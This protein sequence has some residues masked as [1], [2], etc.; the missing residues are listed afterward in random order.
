M[1]RRG[2]TA[3][4]LSVPGHQSAHPCVYSTMDV[5]RSQGIHVYNL[6]RVFSSLEQITVGG[7]CPS[8]ASAPESSYYNCRDCLEAKV[9]HESFRAFLA[10]V[11]VCYCS[12]M[13]RP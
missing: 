13:H 2:R 12:I 11:K 10:N 1:L 3:T 6:G 7:R 5:L 9:F 8:R 4:S